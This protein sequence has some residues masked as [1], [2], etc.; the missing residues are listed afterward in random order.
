MQIIKN[1]KIVNSPW[2]LD[3]EDREQFSF[4]KSTDIF[5][6]KNAIVGDKE[7]LNK[8]IL[9]SVDSWL[10]ITGEPGNSSPTKLNKCTGVF[11]TPDD[12]I[13]LLIDDLDR[14]PVIAL[15]FES[16]TEGRGYSQ[17]V[18]LRTQYNYQGEIRAIGASID[19]LSFMERCGINA[20]QFIDDEDL[21]QALSCFENIQTVYPYN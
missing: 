9:I 6:Q 1:R 17:A 19:N 16:F 3:S 8:A 5:V 15:I 21:E 20:F 18:E 14:I 12:D 4:A 11:V 7:N 13:S 10:G 2:L